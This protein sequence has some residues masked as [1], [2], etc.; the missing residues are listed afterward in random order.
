M[1][2]SYIARLERLE[3]LEKDRTIAFN[4]NNVSSSNDP[5]IDGVVHPSLTPLPNN[6]FAN[7][8]YGMPPNFPIGQTLPFQPTRPYMAAPVGPV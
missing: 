3:D 5:K 6:G 4:D 2:A 1:L 8:L 7:P